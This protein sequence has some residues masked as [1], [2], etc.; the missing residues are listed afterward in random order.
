MFNLK[1]DVLERVLNVLSL[2]LKHTKIAHISAMYK[3]IDYF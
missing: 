2:L 1:R 3:L